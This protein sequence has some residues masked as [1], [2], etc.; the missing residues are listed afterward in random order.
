[1]L[2]CML[3]TLFALIVCAC[4]YCILLSCQMFELSFFVICAPGFYSGHVQYMRMYM[5]VYIVG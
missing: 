4:V 5:Y 3:F 1:M 2:Y